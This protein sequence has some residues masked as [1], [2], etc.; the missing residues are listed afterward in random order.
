[1]SIVKNRNIWFGISGALIALTFVLIFTLGLRFGIDF[2]GGS[3]LEVELGQHVTIEAIQSELREIGY[4]NMTVQA[5]GD[6]GYL[7]R[8]ET[9][10]EEE[11]Q[12]ILQTLE[13]QHGE[14]DE[15]RFDSIGPV[16]GGEL[17]RTTIWGGFLIL[18]LI[19]LY[20]AWAFRK[21]SKPVASWKYG[22]L[23]IVAAF[24]DVIVMVGIYTIMSHL[25]GWEINSAFV[26]ASLTILGYSI[27]DTVVVFDRTRENLANDVGETFEETVELSV[28]QTF[29][30]SINT[31]LTT[32]LALVAIFFFGGESTQPFAFALIVG[33]IVGTYSSIFLASPALVAWELWG[34]RRR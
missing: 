4:S 3:L 26:A 28:R 5:S 2:T 7:I 27:N 6:L 20:I 34:K 21:V 11:H 30:R 22:L 19:G 29:K 23:T 10:S 12:T 14:I 9:L 18:L 31:S 17:R 13:A 25:F 16:I 32:V 33:I 8:T 24:H 1:M 15:L